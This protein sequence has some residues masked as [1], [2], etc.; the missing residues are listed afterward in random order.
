MKNYILQPALVLLAIAVVVITFY[1]TPILYAALEKIP[2]KSVIVFLLFI[3][4]SNILAKI[5]KLY[6]NL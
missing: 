2:Y 6:I 5:T 1:L 3:V 4:A